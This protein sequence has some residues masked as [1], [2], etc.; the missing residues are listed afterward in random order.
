MLLFSFKGLYSHNIW[1]IP[2]LFMITEV[3]IC[4]QKS[5]EVRIWHIHCIYPDYSP[6][7]D[8]YSEPVQ[9]YVDPPEQHS[10]CIL[11]FDQNIPSYLLETCM[12]MEITPIPTCPRPVSPLFPPIPTELSLHLHLFLQNCLF[13]NKNL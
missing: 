9:L 2:C 1:H 7:H 6:A 11:K 13:V 4:R 10:G 3:S 12:V 5:W 8:A